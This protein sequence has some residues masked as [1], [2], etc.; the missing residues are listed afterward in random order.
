ML[1]MNPSSIL[2][3]RYV[4]SITKLYC[5]SVVLNR[6]ALFLRV[7]FNQRRKRVVLQDVSIASQLK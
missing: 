2:G 5:M 6:I 7:P 3:Y 1:N 4:Q